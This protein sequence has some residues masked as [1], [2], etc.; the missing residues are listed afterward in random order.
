MD[1]EFHRDADGELILDE[2]S[3]PIPSGICLCSA[4][5]PSEC[6]CGAWDDVEEW[7]YD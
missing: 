4:H 7:I 6:I 2:D 1:N 5:S 3:N